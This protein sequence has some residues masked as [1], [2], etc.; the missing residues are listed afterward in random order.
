MLER[1]AQNFGT[2]AAKNN[3]P[4]NSDIDKEFNMWVAD[5][6]K[7]M[8]LEGEEFED[9]WSH[10]IDCWESGYDAY[11]RGKICRI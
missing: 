4:R 3:Q 1:I 9:H 8:E 11:R 6:A 5:G 2:Q 10:M 7:Q